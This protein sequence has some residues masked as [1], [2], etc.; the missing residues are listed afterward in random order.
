MSDKERVLAASAKDVNALFSID[1]QSSN[2][3]LARGKLSDWAG[4]V[5][6][7]TLERPDCEK[8]EDWR[9]VIPYIMVVSMGKVLTYRRSKLAGEQ[10]LAGKRSLGFG[11]HITA[12]KDYL[13]SHL[14]NAAAA[15]NGCQNGFI[16]ELEEELDLGTHN[17]YSAEIGTIVSNVD[18]TARAHVGLFQAVKVSSAKIIDPA[19][20]EPKWMTVDEL[21]E[22]IEEFEPWSQ[23]AIK[24][25]WIGEFVPVLVKP[26]PGLTQMRQEHD[27]VPVALSAARDLAYLGP[28]VIS[29]LTAAY[30]DKPKHVEAVQ[31]LDKIFAAAC[32]DDF[33]LQNKL[34][35]HGWFEL[36]EDA[37][38]DVF[39]AV[40][41]MMCA[42]II[43]AMRDIYERGEKIDMAAS[44]YRLFNLF[45]A[46]DN[47]LPPTHVASKRLHNELLL[48]MHAGLRQEDIDQ[49]V[50]SARRGQ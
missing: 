10:R 21:N 9:Q 5:E 40:G 27:N 41:V 7:A 33:D 12:G 50:G 38:E 45:Y 47:K 2:S 36:D 13:D 15:I 30:T 18:A 14:L 31:A 44:V 37:R 4:E 17:V 25:G 22:S 34:D 35:K 48:A 42:S 6:W 16:R 29:R 49:I 39:Y 24:S 19:Y 32:E 23:I 8:D 43:A 1:S 3:V 11:G 46:G 26:Q 28:S 20:M